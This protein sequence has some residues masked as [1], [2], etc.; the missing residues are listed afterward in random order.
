[1]SF[2]VEIACD[3]LDKKLLRLRSQSRLSLVRYLDR[4]S[5]GKVSRDTAGIYG[6]RRLNSRWRL[7]DQRKRRQLAMILARKSKWRN[8][9]S[10]LPNYRM[11]LKLWGRNSGEKLKRILSFLQVSSVNIDFY[12]C[13]VS[14]CVVS[15]H[16]FHDQIVAGQIIAQYNSP[17]ISLIG[18]LLS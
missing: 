8:S 14:L 12:V 10:G 18:I 13:Y 4:G 15:D 17:V 9:S 11:N 1:M 2:L 3:C 6:R 7:Y 5:L 16:S